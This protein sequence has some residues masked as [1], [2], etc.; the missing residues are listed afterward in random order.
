MMKNVKKIIALLAAVAMATTG[1]A[2]C[3]SSAESSSEAAPASSEAA[4]SA[5]SEQ[6]TSQE[7]SSEAA[8]GELVPGTV[9]YPVKQLTITCPPR[10][11]RWNRSADSGDDRVHVR[12]F[13]GSRNCA[14]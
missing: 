5:A 1:L 12:V 10:C 3:G 9:K 13:R 8:D 7:A 11:W 4:S 14:E 6:A 2:G